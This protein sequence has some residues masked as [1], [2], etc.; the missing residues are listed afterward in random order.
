MGGIL[1]GSD[2]HLTRA[3]AVAVHDPLVAGEIGPEGA[4]IVI[5]A[6]VDGGGAY[7]R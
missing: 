3:A 2:V 6:S 4:R 1:Q 5:V 7:R